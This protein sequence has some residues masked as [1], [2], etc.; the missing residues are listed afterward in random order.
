MEMMSQYLKPR[1]RAVVPVLATAV[2]VA[3]VGIWAAL[4][5]LKEREA[6]ALISSRTVVLRAAQVRPPVVPPT[7]AETEAQKQWATLKSERDFVWGPL[8]GAIE[9][10]SSADIELLEFQPDKANRR[11]MLRGEARDQ[12]AL[13]AFVDAL[14]EQPV[15]KRVHLTHQKVRRRDRLQTVVFE[16]KAGL[17]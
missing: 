6:R 1:P 10:A 7:K 14:A 5:A 16:I 11:V 4:V 3:C 2:L 8:F 15:L 13:V 9:K 12:A 17:K